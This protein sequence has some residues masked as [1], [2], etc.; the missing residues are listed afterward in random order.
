MGEVYIQIA[1]SRIR[2]TGRVTERDK[3]KEGAHVEGK[4]RRQTDRQ[5]EKEGLRYTYLWERGSENDTER[6]RQ[7]ET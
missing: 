2:G 6:V 4:E 3:G 5:T 7:S 1:K